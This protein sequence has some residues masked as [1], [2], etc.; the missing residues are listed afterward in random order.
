[1]IKYYSLIEILPS[2]YQYYLTQLNTTKHV[3]KTDQ[4]TKN[5]CKVSKQGA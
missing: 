4:S 2:M 3:A 5:Y 1:M